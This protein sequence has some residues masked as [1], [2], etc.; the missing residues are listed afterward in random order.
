[1]IPATSRKP[2]QSLGSSPNNAFETDPV[3]VGL[4]MA[5]SHPFKVS[6]PAP[7]I[8][9]IRIQCILFSLPI[10]VTFE[11]DLVPPQTSVTME[12][13]RQDLTLHH[14]KTCF[15]IINIFYPPTPTT[16]INKQTKQ[17]PYLYHKKKL[18]SI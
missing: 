18:L 12:S 8:Q 6:H 5:L 2:T 16:T 13:I 17:K 1:M 15:K 7:Y 14:F 9:N 10:S 4:M 11:V 3:L